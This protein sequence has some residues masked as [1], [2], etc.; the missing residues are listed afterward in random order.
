MSRL[1]GS[2]ALRKNDS[3]VARMAREAKRERKW[4]GPSGHMS[5]GGC[6]LDCKRYLSRE[7]LTR[8]GT[9]KIILPDTCVWC[10]R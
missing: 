4:I 8:S 2:I 1:Y 6:C 9:G 5:G 10:G 3:D 7:Y